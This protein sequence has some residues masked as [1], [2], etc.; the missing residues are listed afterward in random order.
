MKAAHVL[1]KQGPAQVANAQALCMESSAVCKKQAAGALESCER[2]VLERF[3][4]YTNPNPN[5]PG[6]A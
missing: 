2:Y 5:Q 1:E 4:T 6:W 3:A